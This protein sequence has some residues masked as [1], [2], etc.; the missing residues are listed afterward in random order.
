MSNA[1]GL[2]DIL[3]LTPLQEGLL[4]QSGLDTEG[5]D[6][7]NVQIAL[8]LDGPLEPGRLRAAADALLR[9]H[10]NIRAA[11]RRRKDGRPAALVG[12]EV[13]ADF[14][15][16]DISGLDPAAQ[17]AEVACIRDAQRRARF[18][19]ARP[20]LIRFALARR[21]PGSHV[22]VLT[23]HHILLDGWSL[24]LLVRDLFGLYAGDGAP[25]PR[26]APFRDYLAWLS[27]QDAGAALTAWREALT[28][29]EGPTR[30]AEAFDGGAAG[31]AERGAAESAEPR[32]LSRELTAESTAAVR[33]L[34]RARGVTLNTVMQ[35]A[36]G[37]VLGHL[38][39]TG[40]VLFG[41]AVSGRP[42][43]LPGAQEM[44]GLFINTV[45]VRV[46]TRPGESAAA[47]LARLRDDQAALLD[48]GHVGLAEIQR[49]AGVPELF[50]TL[51]VVENYPVDGTDPA[52][53]VPGLS[54]RVLGSTDATHYPLSLAVVPPPPDARRPRL[55]LTLG[56]RP[57]AVDEAR[58]ELVAASLT[59]V[60]DA[61]AQ[62][63][64]T[65]LARLPVVPDHL[66]PA[67]TAAL[68]AR[69]TPGAEAVAPVPG[70]AAAADS[71][72]AAARPTAGDGAQAGAAPQRS[73][74]GSGD[75][76]AGPVHGR[77]GADAGAHAAPEDSGG[78]RSAGRGVPAGGPDS[79]ASEP[80][81]RDGG[82]RL[83]A[84]HA[85]A[86]AEADALRAATFC[87]LLRRRVAEAPDSVMVEDEHAVLTAAESDDRAN[88]I[89]R[90]LLARGAGPERVVALALPRSAE[91]VVAMLAVLKTGGA[92]L[93]LDPDYPDDR[94]GHMLADARPACAVASAELSG[95][96]GA[97]TD[98]P[99]IVLDA[100]GTAA[101]IAAAEPG[102]VTDADRGAPLTP[103][104]AAYLI[105]TSG[106]TG[107]PKG[108]VVS[109][110]GVAKLVST[111][112]HRLGADTHSRI[113]QLGSPSFDVA[114]WEF[115]MGVLSG[116][117]LVVVPP[118]R[119][120][121]GPPLTDYLR[122]RGVTHAGL[123]PA[124]L[125][126]LPADAELPPGMTVLAGTEAVP[127]ALVRRF[128]ADGRAMFNCYGPT[129][130]TVNATLAECR[131]DT[132]GDRV[133][134]GRPDPGVRAYVLDSMLRPVPA[135]TAGE[136]YLGGAGPARGYRGQHGLTAARFVADPFA[137]GGAR[138]YRTGDQVLWNARAELEFLGRTDDQVKIRGMRIELGEVEAALAAHPG[139]AA[140]AAVVHR[141][142]AGTPALSAYAT[143]LPG[144]TLL[145][146]E[147]RDHLAARLPSAMVPAAVTVL[148]A[149]PTLPNGKTDRT[150]L[151]AP[152]P[153]AALGRPPRNQV[154]ELLCGLYR[155][156]LEVPEAGI[157]DDFFALGGHSLLA[158][159]LVTRIRAVLGRDVELRTVFDAPTV[160]AL[161]ER[162][163]PSGGRAPLR[164]AERPER[165]P[166][167]YAQ[168]RMW[169]LYRLDGPRPTY[170][171]TFCA[172]LRGPLDRAALEAALADV[173]A[174]HE[175]L[176]TVFPD[177]DGTPY[178]RILPPDEARPE[179]G[180][181][182]TDEESLPALL[183]EAAAYGFRLDS[184]PPLSARLFRTAEDEHVLLVL[185]HHIAGDGWSAR[186]LLRDIGTAYT[187]R[188]SGEEPSWSP[189]PVQYADYGLHQ[190][191][192]LG[193]EEDPGS[194]V[195]VQARYWREAL[196]GLPE[197][198]PLPTDRPR[199]AAAGGRGAS[200]EI[201]LPAELS[202]RLRALARSHDTSVFMVLQAALAALL[203]RLGAG[204]DIPIGSPV[205]GRDDAALD[206]L[207]GFFVNTLV[208]RTDTSGDPSFAELLA[209]VREANLAAYENS[210]IPF[211]RLVEVVNPARSLSRHP[212]FQVMLAYQSG[213]APRLSMAG[214]EASREPVDAPTGK[215]DLA[216][217][218]RDPGEAPT[219]GA[220]AESTNADGRMRCVVDYS[221]DL[222][223]AATAGNIA[224]RLERL[225]GAAAADPAA[226]IGRLD[227][228]TPEE[229][230]RLARQAEGPRTP[231]ASPATLPALFEAA[232]AEGADHP[233]LVCEAEH[234]TFAELNERANRL[235]R[236]LIARGAGPEGIVA[237][238]LPRS[239]QPLVALLAVVKSGAAYLP[240]DPGYPDERIAGMLQDAAP[241]LTVTTPG[242]AERA[243]ALGAPSALVLT[244]QTAAGR[245][246]GDI[247]DTERTVALHP[248]H[249]AYVIYTSGSTGR[250]KGVVVTHRS[251]ANL[252]HSH[253]ET[254]HR[255]TRLRA[256][257]DRLRVGHA[258][259]FSF[260]AAWQPQLW[261]LDGHAVHV[262]TEEAMHDP[263][264]LVDRIRAE[265]IDFIEV[266]PSHLL[267]LMRAGLAEPGTHTPPTLGVGGEPVPA[268]LWKR[269][270]ELEGQGTVTVNLYGPTETT[271]DALA[272]RVG[273][274]ER[275]IVGHPTANT[276]AYVL[277]ERLRPVPAGVVGEL[278]LGGA[279][280]A[281][282]Y[283]HRLGLTA[284]RFVADPFGAPGARMYRTGDLVRR[285]PDGA[286]DYVGRADD[287][288]KVRGF[289]VEPGEVAAA[290]GTHPG[291]DQVAVDTWEAGPGDRRL[292]AYIVR[293]AQPGEV[294]A[295]GSGAS[296]P[297]GTG[298]A[299]AAE[300]RAHL[301]GRLPDYM[302]P[303]AFLPLDS[304]PLTAHGKLDRGALPVP[305]PAEFAPAPGREPRDAA[306]AVLCE[307]FAEVLGGPR[308]GADDDFF[309]LG[310][311]SML[312][313]RLRSRIEAETGASTAVSD[314][315]ANSSP[316]ALAAHLAAR[317][318]RPGDAA[319]EGPSGT[320]AAKTA[321]AADGEPRIAALRAFGEAPPLFCVHPAGGFSWPFVGLRRHLGAGVP[322]LGVEAPPPGTGR[323]GT[324]AELARSYVDRIRRIQPHG[325]YRLAGWSFG[326]TLAQVMAAELAEAGEEVELLALLDAYP[327]PRRAERAA[328]GGESPRRRRRHDGDPA[329]GS[330]EGGLAAAV[331]AEHGDEDLIAANRRWA[332]RLLS[333]AAGEEPRRHPGDAL[334]F[335]AKDA[336]PGA[337][338]AWEPHIAGRIERHEV[339]AVHDELLGADGLAVIGPVL[340]ARLAAGPSAEGAR[341]A[342]AQPPAQ[343]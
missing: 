146:R 295:G 241:L 88:R 8:E 290:L 182:D 132:A 52:A 186:P 127:G 242:L 156:I 103:A 3:P 85:E 314:L 55:R 227:L 270:R 122:E 106:S 10:P 342:A 26:A 298:V 249:P 99:R 296:G 53:A 79:G 6:V 2:E 294:S 334:C 46:R 306:E 213:Q 217:E 67:P 86:A 206:D 63:P 238:L 301:A 45:P 179:T 283:L 160:A 144:C 284:D 205:A 80:A 151:P 35:A 150:A 18:D 16:T 49:A 116:G 114:F 230:E 34:A 285:M 198:L 240:I 208:L 152:D 311:H 341:D 126:A 229:S 90:V 129:E 250:P 161:A 329:A 135:G 165:L 68:A 71:S 222:F 118:E 247:A 277:D 21:A 28:G 83:G 223:D 260:D 257:R 64:H 74:A 245:S 264:L 293:K 31:A 50:D 100:P 75:A 232:A 195:Q 256:G 330:E 66:I 200:A 196:R 202:T 166:L 273:G 312:L 155:E 101:E 95:R 20:P 5:T 172:R 70:D 278:Y 266:T 4:F 243:A 51:M 191:A 254:L 326:G 271:V 316:A 12:T 190:R 109:H 339:P 333:E 162:L 41:T 59:T 36:W 321:P 289:R 78:L 1:S 328:A 315:F 280:V 275:P 77:P 287:Q 143:P 309:D 7:Y 81:A 107:V 209:R 124:L 237:L 42:H 183:A 286:I 43:E 102:E 131:A 226:P 148:E 224:L 327:A 84:A 15:E 139:V 263:A 134:I 276:S 272:A 332:A 255:P 302:V 211:E 192:V 325:P 233:A 252:F 115:A 173:T 105:Y 282:G 268:S 305:D 97:L 19:P 299:G 288:V 121:P 265:R 303:A 244:A 58:A 11:F 246:S 130:A 153:A 110:A 24:P 279:G 300:L 215:F 56:Y 133:P 197:E 136:L 189:L 323:P 313:V 44:V 159:R 343:R 297:Q 259:S 119:R 73:A 261:L 228:L 267:Q 54:A 331:G 235:A 324:V 128:A 187:A 320:A 337:A 274:S 40:D 216:F 57:D 91:L 65:P 304:L 137:G 112:V 140:A 338:E 231:V 92:Y 29:I 220:T 125:S 47:L 176:R 171:I 27:R 340:A 33:E 181:T 234:H 94:L 142:G 207:V 96:V 236:E 170:N 317:G 13:P 185:V 219:G 154:E 307:V 203:T 123:P 262:V 258:W 204:T 178:Q 93:A 292:V 164:P 188:H 239:A 269:L 177:D 335:T 141:D 32:G 318:A 39:D 221:T 169:F 111:A 23:H 291:V 117:R 184:E 25:L 210:D 201:A 9:R 253:R 60:L 120:V 22:L 30:I 37:I 281:R 89:A 76:G 322:I 98:A 310:G 248:D 145:V 108:V 168:Q 251:L 180:P 193:T 69:R 14:A 17:D 61:M 214:L 157:D 225:L 319:A 212:L 175:T 113:A 199:P 72:A 194:A 38:L 138:M 87:E 62:S 48:H 104:G 336:P 308:V 167:S 218:F 174:R 158:T 82:S 147:L 149:M 163:R